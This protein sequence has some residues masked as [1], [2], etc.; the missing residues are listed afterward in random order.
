MAKVHMKAESE[1]QIRG[2]LPERGRALLQLIANRL[3]DPA[4]VPGDPST[5]L[6]YKECC[7]ALGVAPPDAD[8]PWG[9][10]LQPH[11]LNDLNG[12][13]QRHNFPRITG[14]IVNQTGDRQYWPGGDYFASNGRPDMDGDWW[15][16]QAREAARI[17]WQ[18]FL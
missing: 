6:G 16:Q 12:W 1:N 5:Y 13:T 9:R 7:V 4:F 3:A 15:E 10:L 11:G 14:L 2:D 18:P 17:K 8:L